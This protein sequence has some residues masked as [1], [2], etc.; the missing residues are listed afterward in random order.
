MDPNATLRLIDEATRMNSETREHINNLRSWI[1]RGGFHPDWN[2]YPRGAARYRKALG[3][4]E[5][6]RA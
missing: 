1:A 6:L 5:D 4:G 3:L 2:E